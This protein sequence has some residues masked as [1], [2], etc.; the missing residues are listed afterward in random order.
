M[1][2]G[3]INNNNKVPEKEDLFHKLSIQVSLNGLSFCVL[4]SLEQKLELNHSI[5]FEQ[6]LTP[7]QLQ[8]ELRDRLRNYKVLEYRFYEVVAIHSNMLNSLVPQALFHSEQLANYIKY[9]ARILPTDYLEFDSLSGMEIQNVY[10]PYTNINNYLFE[11]FGEFEF[12]HSSSV[13][14]ETL[15]KIHGNNSD[16][17]GYV[18]LALNQ[19]D[20][21]VFSQK[22]LKYFNSFEIS[23]E[24][25]FLYYL[26]F[27]LEQLGKNPN[28]FKLRLVGD[29]TEGDPVFE[30]A[31]EYFENLSILIPPTSFPN[32]KYKESELDFTLINSL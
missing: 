4:D 20:F 2:K 10:V 1:T 7:Y 5:Q 8:H 28:D 24:V 9:N 25:D 3:V 13:L 6:Q 18:H 19:I 22:K 30:T 12:R 32:L 17:I 31:S 16:T 15:N 14:L 26:L 23:S 21:A 27:A 11:L 29:I